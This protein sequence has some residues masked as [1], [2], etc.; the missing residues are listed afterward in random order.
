VNEIINTV[1]EDKSGMIE[2]D[3]FLTIIKN[4]DGDEKSQKIYQFFKGMIVSDRADMT[5][6][7]LKR[8]EELSFNLLVQKLRREH[9]FVGIL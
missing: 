5:T 6:G 1:D 3:E 8:N 2:F 9:L 4:S 7:G